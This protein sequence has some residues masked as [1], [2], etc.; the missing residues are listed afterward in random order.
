MSNLV[1]IVIDSDQGTLTSLAD[2]FRTLEDVEI[3]TVNRV[4]YTRP[5]PGL[6][7]IFLVLPAAERWG[8]KPIPG[9][10]QVLKTT[11]EDQRSG[12]PSFVVTGVVLRRDDPRGPLPE[13]KLLVHSAL[14]A[15]RSFNAES[16]KKI[17]R[18]GFWAVNLLNGVSP[19]QLAQVF[20][21][22]L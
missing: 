7:A 16:S 11:S 18:L 5:P 10:A 19:Q 2:A 21:E 20:S 8:A 9:Q 4:L 14:D 15:V 13:T 22:V 6:D 3:A 12:M 17:H 1:I